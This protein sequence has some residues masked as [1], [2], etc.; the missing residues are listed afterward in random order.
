MLDVS[1]CT[2]DGKFNACV[3]KAFTEFFNWPCKEK[4]CYMC[5]HFCMNKIQTLKQGGLLLV[6]FL[7]LLLNE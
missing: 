6:I 3:E 5:F 2:C 1:L 7:V 4:H